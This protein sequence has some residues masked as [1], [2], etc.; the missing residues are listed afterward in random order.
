VS[1]DVASR[2]R[3]YVARLSAQATAI[4]T[5]KLQKPVNEDGNTLADQKS[6]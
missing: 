3:H 5:G 6:K 1:D 4:T 2:A